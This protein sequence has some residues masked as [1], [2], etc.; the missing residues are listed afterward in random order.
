MKDFN[1]VYPEKVYTGTISINPQGRIYNSSIWRMSN[2][3][4][5][6][7]MAILLKDSIYNYNAVEYLNWKLFNR[8]VFARSSKLF[9]DSDCVQNRDLFRN[10]GYSIVRD[11]ARADFF[12]LPDLPQKYLVYNGHAVLHDTFEDKLYI[13]DV[14]HYQDIPRANIAIE[15]D[16]L[17]N[18]FEHPV[19][20]LY[21]NPEKKAKVTFIPKLQGYVDY[22][23]K[24]YP[25]L[26]YTQE[27][28]VDIEPSVNISIETLDI[29]RNC[30]YPAMLA[31]AISQS[32][33]KE[34]PF[35]TYA[36][37]ATY[38]RHIFDNLSSDLKYVMRSIGAGRFDYSPKLDVVLSN[39]V[40]K[41][42]DWNMFQDYIFH[43]MN[44]DEDA[45]L[46]DEKSL[47]MIE[48]LKSLIRHK[49]AVSKIKLDKQ[50][51]FGQIMNLLK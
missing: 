18:S 28:Q 47:N 45:G 4:L 43:V 5:V 35:T 48:S 9:I 3:L 6:K 12:V 27:S 1:V 30:K 7:K 15:L 2:K 33:Y 14:D 8:R 44:V 20:V 46:V 26:F 13:L 24:K 31:K 11:P 21:Y 23:Y 49:T 34:Y 36:F 38:Q 42:K 39:Y 17:K 29:W 25:N 51:T 10:S 32:N 16:S 40:I 22:L 19:E 50:S 41:P 37:L